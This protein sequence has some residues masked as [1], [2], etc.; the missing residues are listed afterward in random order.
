MKELLLFSIFALTLS[1]THSDARYWPNP[2]NFPANFEVNQKLKL[3]MKADEKIWHAKTL[4]C[5][6]SIILELSDPES[7]VLLQKLEMAKDKDPIFVYQAPAMD[8]SD[9]AAMK[10]ARAI[11]HLYESKNVPLHESRY[12]V[13][14]PA[15]RMMYRWEELEGRGD[16]QFPE[17]ILLKFSDEKYE[18]IMD[19]KSLEC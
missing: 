2:Y 18:V 8:R 7:N 10:I 19:L 16:C 1:C 12:E 13:K 5:A 3:R 6:D 4:R 14:G 9:F 11:Q 17:E 15:A